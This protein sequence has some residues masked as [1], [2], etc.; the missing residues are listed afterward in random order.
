M[1][2]RTFAC[3]NF[4]NLEHVAIEPHPRF[5][6]L[7]GRNG[8]GKT[9]ILEA[10]GLLG[11][12]KSFR[13]AKNSQL[14]QFEKQRC[15]IAAKVERSDVVREISIETEGK[16]KRVRIDGKTLTKRSEYLG[17][18]SIV[19]F[20][21]DHL[22]LT[23]EGPSNRRRF[24]DRAVFNLWPA[25][26]EES[27][28][29]QVALKNR[30]KLLK[31][32]HG[33]GIDKDVMSSFDAEF[34]RSGSR[35]IWR[36]KNFLKLYSGLF[37]E[38]LSKLS[39]N[40][41]E[42]IVTYGAGEALASLE[43][44]SDIQGAFEEILHR[45]WSSD[46]HRRYT[47]VGPHTHDLVCMLNGKSTRSFASQGQHR[48]FVLALKIAQIQLINNQLGFFPI[49]LLDDVSSELDKG[50]NEDLMS[51]L[52]TAG[53]QIFITTTDRRWIQ[54]GDNQQVFDVSGGVV[55]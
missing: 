4:R 13:D 40:E 9:N 50:R 41:L 44:E 20:G 26:F 21:P 2:L 39:S 43:S 52:N 42:G 1:H 36:R 47:T 11:S 3:Q 27:R 35:L 8:Q 25:Y 10:I 33:K 29:Y 55:S 16:G 45:A 48:A 54:L 15:H 18:V 31:D 22:A 14:I 7:E 49:L 37:S 23:K 34:I 24:L 5:N 53:A 28:R 32:S 30:N 6:I 17:H 51:Y 12:F 46:T 38:S 19:F